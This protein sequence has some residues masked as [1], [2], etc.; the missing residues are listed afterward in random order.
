MS[1]HGRHSNRAYRKALRLRTEEALAMQA[2]LQ[3]QGSL[4]TSYS[5][6][7]KRYITLRLGITRQTNPE[8]F[9]REFDLLEQSTRIEK[10]VIT[11][12][13]DVFTID[14]APILKAFNGGVVFVAI[15]RVK[16]RGLKPSRTELKNKPPVFTVECLESGNRE[17][18][19]PPYMMDRTSFCFGD[20]GSYIQALL[21]QGEIAQ[22]CHTIL[23][24]LWHINDTG[25]NILEG[26][27]RV[28]QE[29]RP[30]VITPYPSK[31]EGE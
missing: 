19:D 31:I 7:K 25:E 11:P 23:G 15:Y 10:I 14:T 18:K 6:T 17:G 3:E 24:S 22:A 26:H 8:S 9:A 1:R 12:G 2:R 20:R 28:P 29:W 27:K 13:W 4:P 5:A 21:V 16:I 30:E